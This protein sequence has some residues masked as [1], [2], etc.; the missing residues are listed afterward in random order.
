MAQATAKIR[1]FCEADP[2]AG[3]AAT[4]GGDQA[5]TVFRVIR[6]AGDRA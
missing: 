2:G 6:P 4:F 3:A 5:P 1:L